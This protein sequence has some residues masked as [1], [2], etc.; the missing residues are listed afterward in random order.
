ML[1]TIL[2]DDEPYCLELLAHLLNKHC[3]E[4][5]IVAQF[6]DAVQALEFLRNNPEPDVVFMDVEMPKI[7][8]FDLLNY[9]YPFRFK[10]VFT[11]SFK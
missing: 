11:R 10:V 7:N 3:P 2:L 5:Q 4:V 6:T 9:L 8:A 1:K